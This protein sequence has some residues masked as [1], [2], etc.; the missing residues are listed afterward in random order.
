VESTGT[1]R[2][3]GGAKHPKKFRKTSVLRL[4]G[5]KTRAIILTLT[6]S[7]LAFLYGPSDR[8]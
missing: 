1:H 8:I 2:G 4:F 6:V 3:N 7:K 5:H